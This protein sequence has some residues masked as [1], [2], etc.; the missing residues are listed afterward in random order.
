MSAKVKAQLS[1]ASGSDSKLSVADLK[2][3][4][5]A[6]GLPQNGDKPTLWCRSKLHNDVVTLNLVTKDGELPTEL[7]AGALKKA[8]A[9][10]GVSPIGTFDELLLGLVDH[11]KQLHAAAATT[12]TTTTS[13]SSD[14]AAAKPKGP[15]LAAAVLALADDSISSPITILHLADPTLSP[16]S[17]NAL[18]RKAYLKL[19]LSI[20]PDRI[21][22]VFPEA[23]RAFQVLVT[24]FE[25]LTTPQDVPG[26]VTSKKANVTKIQR[27]NEGCYKTKIQCPRCSTPWG[28]KIEGNPDYYYNIMMSGLK[29]FCCR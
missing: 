14:S 17:A 19:S 8:A 21:S 22:R 11:L 6:S 9:R 15:A 16:T 4:L 25:R 29:S 2:G 3:Y 28:D 12:E 20:H 18:L 1:S 26:E 23:T 13:S 7:K 10:A 27:S 24:A 5:K